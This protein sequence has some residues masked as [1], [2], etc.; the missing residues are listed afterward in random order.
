MS[1]QTINIGAAPNDGTGDPLR[2]AFD[3]TND[4][5]DELY[6]LAPTADQ[7]AA[8]VGTSGT[9]ASGNKYVTNADT[10]LTD[11]RN[12]TGAAGGDLTG[13]YPNPT[14]TTDAITNAKL[15]NMAQNTIKGRATVGTG[16]PEDLTAS[17]VR[18]AIDVYSKAETP[19]TFVE[20]NDVPSSY[21]GHGSKTVKVK[22]D[23][24]GL[25]FIADGAGY[26]DE[27]AQD[28]VGGIL[29][30]GTV[31]D[32]NFTYDDATPKIS[33]VIDN[34]AIT[35]AKMAD[36]AQNTIKGRV[37]A[38]TGDPEDLSPFDAR[39]VIDVYSKSEV[40]SIAVDNFLELTDT[41]SS[42]SGQ[43]N[44]IV[45]VN[46][47]AT[48]LEFTDEYNDENAQDAVG[49]ILD[50]GTAGDIDFD[51]NDVTPLISANVKNDAITNAKLNNMAQNTI[52]GRVTASTGDP[53][54]L[55]ATQGRTVLDVYSKSEVNALV[56]GLWDDRGNYDPTATSD[57]PTT[58]GSGTAG[59]ILK[60]DIWTVSV[61][62]TISGNTVSVGDTVRALVDSPGLTD[63]NWAIGAV[64]GDFIANGSTTTLLNNTVVNG[65]GGLYDFNF[66]TIASMQIGIDGG[67]FEVGTS[68]GDSFEV[69]GGLISAT[70]G[71]IDLTVTNGFSLL[72]GSRLF[73]VSSSGWELDFGSDATGDIY[74]RDASGFLVR[75][76]IGT[77]G[78]FLTAT[79][80]PALPTWSSLPTSNETTSGIVELA[81]AA[82]TLTGTDNT[83]AVHSAGVHEK[84][85]GEQDL[86]IPDSAMWPRVTNG[87]S[88]LTRVEMTT[89]LFNIQCLEFDETTQQFA[90]FQVSLPRNWN[91]GTITARVYWTA[92]SGS[93]TVQWGLSG[94]AYSDN[95]DLTT[96][97]GTA[98]TVDDTFLGAN[99]V[100][101]TDATSAITLAGSPA[102]GD[103]IGLQISRNPASDT[104]NAKARLLGVRITI[105]TDAAKAA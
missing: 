56:V 16:D 98:Q 9:P 2:T 57:Y 36:M 59:A 75:R 37:T 54:D 51:Y 65:D 50:S 15:A 14:V 13:T 23:A 58:G 86:F 63:A 35:N 1:Q 26:T 80:T 27:N 83:R 74:Y 8:L 90:Q 18:T 70:S 43:A 46:S 52:K 85:V 76:A 81:T 96:A 41:P 21:T 77:S 95:D 105:T 3:K 44:K 84:V 99:K 24:T 32:V 11:S 94:G 67:G 34:D 62:G 33:G 82:E 25:E 87:C 64:S 73:S 17:Q 20:L 39:Q 10:R 47:G 60:G 89:S 4:N 31:G 45:S 79:G 42:Y 69:G 92:A 104:L 6:P 68:A 103:F 97:F 19:Q 30:N 102:D 78:Q 101:I 48:G 28:A 5:F 49:G 12:P 55:T 22:A 91:N 7:K 88:Y 38:S 100:H 40:D 71:D 66:S 61:A 53:E 93:G 29:D 72:F